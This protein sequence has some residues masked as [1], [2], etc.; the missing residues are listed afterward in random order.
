MSMN[1]NSQPSQPHLQAQYDLSLDHVRDY[2]LNSGALQEAESFLHVAKAQTKAEERE[3][4]LAG[5][6]SHFNPRL[7]KERI[8]TER[9]S[10]R[11]EVL[12][13]LLTEKKS[14]TAGM[15]QEEEEMRRLQVSLALLGAKADFASFSACLSG[16]PRSLCVSM[17]SF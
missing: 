8:E 14:G 10:K 9:E 6:V 7:I 12:R 17:Y 16:P 2:L 13:R 4:Q 5:E 1:M 15:L 3:S 11:D